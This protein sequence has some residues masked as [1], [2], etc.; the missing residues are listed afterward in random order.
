MMHRL[1]TLGPDNEPLWV[2]LYVYPVGD[3][4]ASVI[5]ADGVV[6]PGRMR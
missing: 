6:P 5:V 3:Q 4:W 2:Q 1:L